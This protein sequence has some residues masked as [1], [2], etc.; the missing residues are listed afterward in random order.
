MSPFHN[1]YIYI[2]IICMYIYI[3]IYIWRPRAALAWAEIRQQ[4]RIPNFLWVN[5]LPLFG[6]SSETYTNK[7]FCLMKIS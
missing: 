4:I 6:I 7:C 3:Y 2:H 1:I 5:K